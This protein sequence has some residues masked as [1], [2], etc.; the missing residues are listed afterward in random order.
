M[1]IENL[2]GCMNFDGGFGSTPGGESHGGQSGSLSAFLSLLAS[3]ALPFPRF[4]VGN[5]GLRGSMNHS[6]SS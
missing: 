1:L 2:R 3:L 4:R 6:L 5:D